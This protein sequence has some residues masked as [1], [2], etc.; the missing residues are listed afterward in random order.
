MGI[1]AAFEI[2]PRWLR[3]HVELTGALAPSQTGPAMEHTQTLDAAGKIRD[4]GP[5]PR[6]DATIVQTI[7]L[8]LVL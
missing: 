6:L 7:G 3:V 5:M 2:I 8:S 1:G 4:V